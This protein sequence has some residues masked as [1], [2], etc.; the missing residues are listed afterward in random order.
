MGKGE[1]GRGRG[2]LLKDTLFGK[3]LWTDFK[4]LRNRKLTFC[5]Y[6]WSKVE[7]GKLRKRRKG[8]WGGGCKKG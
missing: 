3:G 1:G 2:N 4:N 7:G 8:W 5:F 6:I